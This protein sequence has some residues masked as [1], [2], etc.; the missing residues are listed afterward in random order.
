MSPSPWQHLQQ[1]FE[2]IGLNRR[3]V[4]APQLA[5]NSLIHADMECGTGDASEMDSQQ[6][7]LLATELRVRLLETLVGLDI[8]AAGRPAAKERSIALRGQAVVRELHE[9]VDRASTGSE[10]VRRFL[11]GCTWTIEARHIHNAGS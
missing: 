5:A 9:A 7:A 8:P 3:S 2:S 6:N 4:L 1:I 10:S 11:E